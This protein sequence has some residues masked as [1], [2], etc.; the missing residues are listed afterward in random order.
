[1]IDPEDLP[2]KE[3]GLHPKERASPPC[4]SWRDL[5]LYT[6]QV[7][8]AFNTILDYHPPKKFPTPKPAGIG[9][10]RRSVADRAVKAAHYS[11]AAD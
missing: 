9:Y 4:H 2:L 3:M 11:E 7:H 10:F 8:P 6:K 5:W 1:V